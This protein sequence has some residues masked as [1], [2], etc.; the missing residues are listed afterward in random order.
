MDYKPSNIYEDIIVA[1]KDY[2]A[3]E[4]IDKSMIVLESFLPGNSYF[5]FYDIDIS[6]RLNIIKNKTKTE[7][8]KLSNME[9]RGY[10]VREALTLELNIKSYKYVEKLLDDSPISEL[11]W[12]MDRD[13]CASGLLDI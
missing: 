8:F 1:N 6:E 12:S 4:Y 7:I 10:H 11:T 2:I 5:V 9:K 13:I 3:I